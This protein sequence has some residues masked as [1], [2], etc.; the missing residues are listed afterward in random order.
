MERARPKGGTQGRA[1]A[2][3]FSFEKTQSVTLHLAEALEVDRDGKIAAWRCSSD[4]REIAVKV[5]E[6]LAA[7][8]RAV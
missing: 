6:D 2:P 8:D 4:S 5:G 1:V 7:Q 3:P